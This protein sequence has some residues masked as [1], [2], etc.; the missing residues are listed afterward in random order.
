MGILLI[1]DNKEVTEMVS[2]FLESEDISCEVAN[3]GKKG[4]EKIKEKHYDAI[5]LDLAMPV[6]SGYELF[7][8]LKKENYLRKNNIVIF[9]ATSIEQ[10]KLDR[11]MKDGIKAIIKKPTS[12]NTIIETIHKF[13]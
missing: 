7:D 12:I 13:K 1:D 9:T 10:E 4:L 11:M 3:D 2:F 8:D 6:Y 5:L